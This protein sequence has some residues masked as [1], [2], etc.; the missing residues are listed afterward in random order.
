MPQNRVNIKDDKT[1]CMNCII[2][3]CCSLLQ[4]Y[5]PI[6]SLCNT[7]FSFQLIREEGY[8]EL[9]KNSNK[10]RYWRCESITPIAI[11]KW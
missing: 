7:I 8:P 10:E 4:I 5:T 1:N 9:K 11:S 2:D 6:N 3:Y